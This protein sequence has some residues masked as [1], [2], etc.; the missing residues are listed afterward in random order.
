MRGQMSLS[1]MRLLMCVCV[2][3][4]VCVG[5][6]LMRSASGSDIVQLCDEVEGYTLS[7][8]P[9]RASSADAQDAASKLP[10]PW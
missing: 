8:P 6:F 7:G 10:A 1:L 4:C 9:S 2:C 5:S 3:V